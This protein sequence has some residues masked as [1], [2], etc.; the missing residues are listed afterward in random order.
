MKIKQPTFLL[1]LII[2]AAA[3]FT[4]LAWTGNQSKRSVQTYQDTT[5]TPQKS[6][7]AKDK[8][9]KKDF[10]KELDELDK[11]MK[12]LQHHPDVDFQK[13]RDEI[14]ISMKQVQEQMAKHK[15]DM[16]KMQKEL[17]E[18]LSKIDVDKIQADVK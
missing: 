3:G 9:Y 4:S 1:P 2:I 7:R 6:S 17:H 10:D 16:E 18:Y 13:I 14:D 12:D 8:E 15:I 11:A 5:P